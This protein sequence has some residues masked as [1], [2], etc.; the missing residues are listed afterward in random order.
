MNWHP[1]VGALFH[2]LAASCSTTDCMKSKGFLWNNEAVE[3]FE[4]I[5]RRLMTAPNLVLPDFQQPLNC[6]QMLACKIGIWTV[7]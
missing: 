6:I 4:E 2:T 1:F 5:K 3:A 7:Q